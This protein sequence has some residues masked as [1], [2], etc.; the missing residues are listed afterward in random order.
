MQFVVNVVTTRRVLD[1]MLRIEIADNLGVTQKTVEQRLEQRRH[2]FVVIGDVSAFSA[3]DASSVFSRASFA[4][5]IKVERLYDAASKHIRWWFG[6]SHAGTPPPDW[7]IKIEYP[8]GL[9]TV[10][11]TCPDN[12]PWR[13][14]E[15]VLHY[16]NT[17]T[18]LL[19]AKDSRSASEHVRG[20]R[21][22]KHA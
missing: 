4:L 19:F 11:V 21:G 16:D 10:V 3:R 14:S 9:Q 15:F 2:G 12:T 7:Q 18:E 1:D 6:V 5:L 17:T 20:H 13:A 22:R 8:N